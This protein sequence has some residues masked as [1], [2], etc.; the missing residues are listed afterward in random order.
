MFGLFFRPVLR[1]EITGSKSMN[2]NDVIERIE[3]INIDL[4]TNFNHPLM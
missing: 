2:I 3:V 1:R 4:D